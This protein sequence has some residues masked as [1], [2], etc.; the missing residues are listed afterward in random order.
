MTRHRIREHVFKL[1]FET[2]FHGE[3]ELDE[4]IDMYWSIEKDEPNAAE[5][6]EISAKLKGIVAHKDEIDELVGNNAKGWKLKRIGNADLSILRLA[7]YEI[8]WDD[9]VPVKVA[10]NE[11]VELA[12]KYGMDRAPAFINGILAGIVK[13][14][15]KED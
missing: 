15:G 2:Q 1:L 13:E 10:I 6:G 11:A 4:L 9:S 8:M 5:Y 12:K 14:T 7:V 3:N